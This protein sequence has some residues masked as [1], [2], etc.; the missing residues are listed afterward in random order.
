MRKNYFT[1]SFILIMTMVNAQVLESDNYNSYNL[2]D[3]GTDITGSIAGQG[4]NF[5]YRGTNADYQ[6]VNIDAGHEKSLELTSVA[7]QAV[8]SNRAV[9]KSG[10]NTAWLNRTTGNDIL[11]VT[12]QIYTGAA[13]GGK[14]I[15]SETIAT[16]SGIAGIYFN[17]LTK[18]IVCY[19]TINTG[20][21]TGSLWE[22]DGIDNTIYP[23]NT[24]ISVA[25][26]YN[27][28]GNVTF[29]INGVT[30]TVTNYSFYSVTQGKIPSQHY[31]R[32]LQ[33]FENTTTIVGTTMAIDNVVVE[34][35]SSTSLGISEN[36]PSDNLGLCI[37]PNPAKEIVYLKTAS[38]IDFVRI[39][40]FTGKIIFSNT[41]RNNAIDV[42]NFPSGI[43]FIN[44]E[45][46]NGILNQK[47]VKE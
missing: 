36:T 31:I 27:P 29:I 41:I 14:L 9:F 5:T 45:T 35:V 2:G 4:N 6:I 15:G 32:M 19:A 46:E 44:V 37:Y 38:K 10:L 11:K 43:Y 3:L 40:D 7:T 23:L 18:K 8:S 12:F 34:A 1:A 33:I 26:I 22:I 28:L 13:A 17:S 24:W 16:D 25:Y 42:S 47:F 20:G 21:T 39:M 30:T